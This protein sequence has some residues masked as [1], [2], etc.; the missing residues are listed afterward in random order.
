MST[1]Q[2]ISTE[3]GNIESALRRL[4]NGESQQSQAE[5]V[6]RARTL[7]LIAC[8][9]VEHAQSTA[10]LLELVTAYSP[11]RTIVIT[12]APTTSNQEVQVRVCASCLASRAGS[13]VFGR[14]LIVI[15]AKASAH[16]RLPSMVEG[17]L[18]PDLP[19]FLWWRD[20]GSLDDKLFQKF[21]SKA[22]RI[23]VDST[24][25]AHVGDLL[26]L[27][28]VVKHIC[29]RQAVS[30]LAWSRLTVWRELTAQFFDGA[31]G[32]VY[33]QRLN[34]ILV[35]HAALENSGKG[36]PADAIL[37]AAW[38]ASRLQ[39]ARP[40]RSEQKALPV[41]GGK[42]SWQL[43]RVGGSLSIELQ[44]APGARPGLSRLEL[45]SEG[46]PPASFKVVSMQ[47][48]GME[49]RAEIKGNSP[50]R[51][52]VRG[53]NQSPDAM[54]RKELEI[55]G[56]DALYEEVLDVACELVGGAQPAAGN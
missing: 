37:F 14:E 39:C 38:F 6:V 3:V 31:K 30:D 10:E 40:A 16:D 27:Q 41:Q 52:I 22:R 44:S 35:E 8:S 50:I 5:P 12:P 49:T 55:I 4:W 48:G 29:P 15:E 11:G 23:I 51:R 34:R 28:Q 46:N 7:N 24:D 54:V 42:L 43:Q 19:V 33:L 17:L 32:A 26:R 36:I 53:R 56:R 21:S 9:D 45:I 2:Y 25:L 1:L 47:R 18:V 20:L 13:R